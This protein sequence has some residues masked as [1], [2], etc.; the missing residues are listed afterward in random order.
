MALRKTLSL[1]AA[2]TLLSVSAQAAVVI[3][4]FA[5]APA[6]ATGREWVEL[7]NGGDTAV[8]ISGWQL[9]SATSGVPALRATVPANTTLEPGEF[10]VLCQTLDNGNDGVAN[11]DQNDMANSVLGNA[12]SNADIVLI[13]DASERVIDTVVYGSP[14]TDN[15]LDDSLDIAVSLA[16]KPGTG[17]L[18]R[19]QDGVDTEKSG[20]DFENVAVARMTP[21]ALNK[22]VNSSSSSSSG[23]S[24]SS[25]SGS[26]SGGSTSSSSG[27]TSSSGG[28]TSSS[29]GETS[30]SGDVASSSSTSG[31]GSSGSRGPV[32]SE[33]GGNNDGDNSHL[34]SDGGCSTS[35][36]QLA[37]APFGLLI[38]LGALRFGRRRAK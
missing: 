19:K 37:S 2:T 33:D 24:T 21:G 18:A 10:W 26:S 12:T 6:P 4:E 28:S 35:T 16:P 1:F 8:D 29:S 7:Y 15:W 36:P 34:A 38:A 5:A 20:D 13:T 14:N 9:R 3:N 27:E 11:C 31:G 17:S 23:G 22:P 30:S 32:A 25:S